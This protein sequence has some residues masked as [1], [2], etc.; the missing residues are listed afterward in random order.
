MYTFIFSVTQSGLFNSVMISEA[1][2]VKGVINILSNL[3]D[4]S[5]ILNCINTTGNIMRFC[6]F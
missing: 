2:K 1:C 3:F 5:V 4:M 6:R